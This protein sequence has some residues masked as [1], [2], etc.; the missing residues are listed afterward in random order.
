MIFCFYLSLKHKELWFCWKE[1]KKA[2]GACAR[3]GNSN[4]GNYKISQFAAAVNSF[5][6]FSSHRCISTMR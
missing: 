6:L 3:W 4:K 5:F 1:N 2:P